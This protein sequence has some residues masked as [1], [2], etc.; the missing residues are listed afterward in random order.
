MRLIARVLI[1]VSAVLLLTV[2]AIYLLRKPIAKAAVEQV[3]ARAH[4][5]NPAVKVG[6]LSLSKLMLV[7]LKAGGAPT[8]PEIALQNVAI[9]YSW[10]DLVFRGKLKNVVIEGGRMEASVDEHGAVNIAGWSPDPEAAPAP[11]PFNSLRMNGVD[12]V[13]NFPK[14]PA[15]FRVDG[16]LD[17]REGGNFNILISADETGAG[18]AAFSSL[19]GEAAIALEPGGGVDIK[20]AIKSDVSTLLGAAR[21]V[22]ATFS[23][24]GSSWRG[25]FGDGPSALKGEAV[26]RIVSAQMDPGTAPTIAPFTSAGGPPIRQ[27]SLAGA[28]RAIVTGD[29]VS[30]ALDGG[31]LKIT[32]DRGDILAFTSRGGPIYDRRAGVERIAIAADL[33][34]PV[35]AGIASID[36]TS[37][38]KGK[39]TVEASAKFGEQAVGSVMFDSFDGD[40]RG[41]Y[42]NSQIRGVAGF[43]SQVENAKVGR[44][45][46]TNMPTSA[47]L[48]MEVDFR[49]RSLTASPA[50][51][52]CVQFDRGDF[53]FA[54]QD[55]DGRVAGALICPGR[56][57]LATF[58]WGKE[59]LTHVEGL[60]TAKK[61]HYRL[62]KTIFDGVPPQIDFKLDY[63][64][65][66]QSS[67]IVGKIAG[68]KL[69]LNS[70]LILTESVGDFESDL[71]RDTVAAKVA[72]SSMKI[73]QNVELE[74]VAPVF[75]SG[76]ADL[77]NEI[78]TF[79]FKVKTPAG[80]AL[81][82]GEGVHRVKSGAGEAIFDSG[83]IKLSYFLQPDRVIPA[84]RGVISNASGAGEGRARFF[85]TPAG[86]NSAATI[87]LD[88]VSFRGPGVAVSRTEGVS[89]KLVFSNLAPVETEGEQTIS[90]RKI[91]LDALK[92]ENGE[93]R[94]SLPGDNTL[95]I[96]RAEF[97]WFDG[98]IG[99]YNSEMSIAGG[100]SETTLQIDNVNLAGLLAYLNI[101]GLSGEGVVAGVLPVS[102][103]GG[104]ARVNKGVL[105]A[106]GKGV[107]R[108]EGNETAA[109]SQSNEQSALAFEI[110]KE[111]RFEKLSAT[112]DGPLDGTLNFRI[113]FEGRGDIP[114]KTGKGTQR[115]D[116][117][118]KYRINI[119]APLLS[120]IEQ[121]VLSTDI[122]LQIERARVEEAAKQEPQ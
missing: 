45:S 56:S 27:L 105:S 119:D 98:T 7:E 2:T 18:A 21:D 72:I 79:D 6:A 29:G 55:M 87:N 68:G 78:A 53:S 50:A 57:P 76:G 63:R 34:G 88:D 46:L 106:K 77:A 51:G 40:F 82:R 61:A 43:I 23:F 122:K 30:V 121:A 86:V 16:A 110:L 42:S 91:D 94:F 74:K 64:P 60:L 84:L 112:I 92:L 118:V 99:A 58:D 11:P 38:N 108:Y 117:P 67:R 31:P 41:E 13:A 9:E 101:D 39:W 97:P 103:E 36:A 48:M 28:V 80:A 1:G 10:R 32:A 90:I 89:G 19:T 4:L 93:M 81:G 22:D 100:K 96:I 54:D 12:V 113:F 71:V 102:F 116:S 49:K 17:L 109:A 8:E 20:G 44:L 70:A 26:A 69:I 5:E 73:A 3:M 15:H 115:V 62:G 59:A 14:G 120:L 37:I 66:I 111:L 65:A 33:S 25:I 47:N 83:Q 35:A 114:V 75:V 52:E 24:S 107:I 95:K 104:R 85:W